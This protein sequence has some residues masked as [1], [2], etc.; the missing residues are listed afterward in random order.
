MPH[1]GAIDMLKLNLRVPR[2]FDGY[3]KLILELD[4][5][6]PWTIR[7]IVLRTNVS[8]RSVSQF[9]DRLRKAGIAALVET[10]VSVAGQKSATA[11]YRLTRRPIDTPRLYPDGSERPEDDLQL[12]WRTMKMVKSFTPRELADQAGSDDRA[13]GLEL[14]RQYVSRLC[15]VG[16]VA[17][18][19]PVRSRREARYRLVRNLGARAPRILTARVVFDPNAK[20]V[21]GDAVASEVSR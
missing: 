6:G 1:I 13:V 9:V 10:R 18:T 15:A 3:W 19:Q 11:C 21:I 5:H 7:Q 14:T 16:I 17:V 20:Q 12:L 8:T 2:G 4:E